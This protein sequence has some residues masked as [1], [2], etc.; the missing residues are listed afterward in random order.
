MLSEIADVLDK[1]TDYY[2]AEHERCLVWDDP[3]IGI[4]WPLDHEP[5][6]SVKDQS[7]FSFAQAGGF[8][9]KLQFSVSSKPEVGLLMTGIARNMP[10]TLARTRLPSRFPATTRKRQLQ[11]T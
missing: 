6:L 11:R 4:E 9:V 10:P 1:T 3:E 2:C 7:G 5:V 8:R